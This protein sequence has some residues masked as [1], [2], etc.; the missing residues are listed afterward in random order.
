[1][2]QSIRSLTNIIYRLVAKPLLF[3][4]SP[5]AVHGGLLRL[6]GIVQRLPLINLLPEL[7][8]HRSPEILGQTIHGVYYRNPVGLSAGFDKNIE[9]AP[10]MKRVGF[11]FMTGGSVTFHEC[12]GNSRPWFYRLPASQSI[13]VRAGLPNHGVRRIFAR[14]ERYS[15]DV[16]RGF[17]LTVSV[18]KTNSCDTVTDAQAIDDYIGSII[19]L[20][21]STRVTQYEINISCPNT[22]GGE[23]FTTPDK[24][25]K[26]L[27]AIDD[28]SLIRPV[29]IKM[30]IDLSWAEY[31]ALLDII[32]RHNVQ[33][34]TIGNLRKDRTK[35]RLNDRLTD[36]MR[37]GLSG[38]PTREMTTALISRTYAAYGDKLTII[39]VGGI[40]TAEDAYEKIRAG[41]S[42]VEL[43]TGMI[44]GG[45]Q[46]IGQINHDLAQLL[47]RDGYTSIVDAVGADHKTSV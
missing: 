1:M 9:L 31:R 10:L 18:A 43:I 27:T 28:V 12:K 22:H 26:L 7:W 5:D 17:P 29:Y 13:V 35:L 24:L 4:H 41:A 11:G 38:A 40:F 20:E 23:P 34:V 33:G 6:G 16:F 39:G 47:A 44:F 21:R 8:S 46:V 15:P 30:P 32:C 45:P 19:E 42:L 14:L 25:D 36:D 3:H 37:G 2:K